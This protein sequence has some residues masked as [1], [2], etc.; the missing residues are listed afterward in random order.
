[1]IEPKPHPQRIP[2]WM[3]SFARWSV[4]LV[5]AL[6]LMLAAVWGVLHGFIV[7]RIGDWRP[8]LESLASRNLGVPVSIGSIKAFGSGVIPSFELNDVVISDSASQQEALRLSKVVVAVSAHSLMTLGVE[9][10]YIDAPKLVVRRAADGQLFVA[11][12][13]IQQESGKSNDA[14]TDWLFSQPEIAIRHGSVQWT[15]EVR[16]APTLE[17]SDVDL[18]LRN[19]GWSHQLRLDATPPADW[20]QRFTVMGR[21]KEPLL[22]VHEGRMDRWSGQAFADFTQ[23]DLSALGQYLDPQQWQLQQGSGAVRAWLD[24]QQGQAAGLV[25]DVSID[26]LQLQ[27]KDRPKPLQ[28]ESLRG[29]LSLEHKGDYRFAAQGLSFTTG[30]GLHWPAGNIK[31]RYSPSGTPEQ[32]ALGEQ[33]QISAD[34]LDIAIA[35]QL[36]KRLPISDRLQTELDAMAPAG[37][38]H[39]LKWEWR[40]PLA[41]PA[42]YKAS[43]QVQGLSIKAQPS[44]EGPEEIGIPGIKGLN[45]SFS[46]DQD[47]GQAQLSMN[48]AQAPL[49]LST[50]GIFAQPDVGLDSFQAAVRWQVRDQQIRVQVPELKFANT[51]ANAS[52]ELQWHTGEGSTK[53]PL[54]PG[55]LELQGQL[56]NGKAA[57]VHRYLPLAIPHDAR[58][59]VH[60]S[61]KSGQ[62]S[63]VNFKVKGYLDDFPFEKPGQGEFLISAKLHDVNYN[64]VPPYL[65]D[66]G[67][68]AWPELRHLSGELVIDK[69][70]LALRNVKGQI[71]AAEPIVL[72]DIKAGIAD[73]SNPQVVVNA[74]ASGALNDMLGVVRGSAISAML[75][76]ALDESHG[77]GRAQ[78]ALQ[79]H[80]P[81]EHMDS[82]K[83]QGA[84]TVAGN[85]F[86]LMPAV[87]AVSQLHGTLHFSETGFSLDGLKAQ[88]LGGEIRLEGGM[89]SL[90]SKATLA[91]SELNIKGQGTASAQGLQEATS[92]AHVKSL[93]RHLQGQANYQLQIAMRRGQPEVTVRSDLQGMAVNLPS[94]MGKSASTAMALTVEQRLAASSLRSAD[95]ALRD[96]FSL[97]WGTVLAAAYERELGAGAP[98]VLRGFVSLRDDGANAKGPTA[99]QRLPERGVHAE[100]QLKELEL[101]PWLEQHEHEAPAKAVNE[102]SAEGSAQN[103]R[104]YL[105]SHVSLRAGR[106]QAKGRQ[107]SDLSLGL[108]QAGKSWHSNITSK[109]VAGYVEYREGSSQEP[110][111]QIIAKLSRLAVPKSEE[112]PVDSLLD[113]DDE[114]VRELPA[115]DVT[116][117]DMRVG[118]VALGRMEIQARNRAAAQPQ[119]RRQWQLSRFNINTPEASLSANGLWTLPISARGQSGYTQLK[120]ELALRDVGQLLTRFDMPG[121]VANGKGLLSGEVGWIGAPITPDYRSMAGKIHMDVGAGSFLKADPGLAKLLG[122]LSLQALP[123]RLTLDFRDVF[124]NGFS[125]D[126]MRGDVQ[127]QKGVARTNNIQIKGVN[128]AVLMEGSA[129]LEKETQ[130]LHVVIVPEINAMTASLVATAINPVIGLGSFLAQFLLRVPLNAVMTKELKIDG[131]WADPQVTEVPRSQRKSVLSGQNKPQAVPEEVKPVQGAAGTAPDTNES[132][133]LP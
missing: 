115:L 72:D 119:G 40:G 60:Q 112:V 101:D 52:M 126:F 44:S 61:V 91:D 129:D 84:V 1:M 21:F 18:V 86:T 24:V 42:S 106:L 55:V 17:L 114:G 45:A 8:G 19:K 100:V 85:N 130:N 39:Q 26:A 51:D 5:L 81:I 110:S 7:P 62:A 15:D 133:E 78:L 73:L 111:G 68:Q 12:L 35:A 41:A 32:G 28:L 50:P 56:T 94:P 11:G 89:Q 127:I 107:L 37:V 53:S 76:H 95:A 103:S 6:W 132:K 93:T 25:A 105:P 87:P 77:T 34:G 14:V 43:G 67:Q 31:A 120:F 108:T 16:R 92:L 109:E 23:I 69:N 22:S 10:I 48:A 90:G 36:M 131:S 70:S 58:E 99:E 97:Q 30:D 33:G 88:A 38:L 59:Y 125:F 27:W 82:C 2:R 57:S 3:G 9:Q 98:K 118:G 124:R 63:T 79:L 46:L 104:E 74:K 122:V 65:L 13:P 54:F 113:D 49:V 123:R 20:G 29:R 75:E 71:A 64:Y 80:L 128:A 47:S 116:V 83:V 96:V 102:V 4:G 117:D 121:V 66:A